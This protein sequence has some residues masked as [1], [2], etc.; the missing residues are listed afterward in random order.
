MP[1]Q[2]IYVKDSDAN[3]WERARKKAGEAGLS[4]YVT[5]LIRNDVRFSLDG[6]T[7]EELVASIQSDLDRLRAMLA[8]AQNEQ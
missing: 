2:M 1:N 6:P 5:R 3:L 7:P 4:K 8:P